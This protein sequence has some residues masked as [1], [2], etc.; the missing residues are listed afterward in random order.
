MRNVEKEAKK[1]LLLR[2]SVFKRDERESHLQGSKL[3]FRR[4]AEICA[5]ELRTK[6]LPGFEIRAYE[7]LARIR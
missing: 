2:F 5:R 3:T 4:G 1:W 6:N 7:E